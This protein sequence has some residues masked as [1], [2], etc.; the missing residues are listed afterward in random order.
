MNQEPNFEPDKTQGFGGGEER[1]EEPGLLGQ[2]SLAMTREQLIIAGWS[3]FLGVAYAGGKEDQKAYKDLKRGLFRSIAGDDI[4]DILEVGVGGNPKVGGFNNVEFYHHGQ[5]IVGVDPALSGKPSSALELA[6]TKA[7]DLGL[8]LRG[9]GGVAED[10]PF[11]SGSFDA[12]VSTL[13]FC[14]VQDPSLALREVSRV[15]RPGGK[16]LFVEHVHAQEEGLSI[17]GLRQ[18]QD[19]LDPLQQQVAD[20]CHLTRETDRLI[21]NAVGGP[22]ESRLFSRVES[23][24][25]VRVNS[26]W[27]VSEQV[28]GVVVK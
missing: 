22:P 3:G 28:F 19:L 20:G 12:V 26:M 21:K 7:Q 24:E 1:G 15:L 10:L 18:Q 27:P 4:R 8:T 16:F 17:L 14:S 11:A 6:S 2:P 23:I 13:V 5:R 25:T 9:V